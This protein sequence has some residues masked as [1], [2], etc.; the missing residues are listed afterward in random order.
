[1]NVP[2]RTAA[3]FCAALLLTACMP[4]KNLHPDVHGHRGCRG[5]LPEN[6][7]PGF[8]KAVE[9]GC[10][11]LEL[12]VVMSG[13]GQVIVSHEPWM[14]HVICRTAAGDSILPEQEQAFNIYHMTVAELQAFDCGGRPH[15]DFPEQ[16]DRRTSKPT[17]REVVE[18]VD[19][20]AVMNG[21]PIPSYNVEIKSDP[22]WY[23]TF[24]PEP[25]A[26]AEAVIATIDSLG[27]TDRCI[28][29][30]FDPAILE[31]VNA[32]RPDLQ[33]AF[34][35]ENSDGLEQDL[36]RLSFAPAIY[37]PQYTAAD[38]RLLKEL[39]ERGI[40]LVVWTVN[41]PKDIQRMLDLGVDGIISDYPD[42]VIKQME[43]Q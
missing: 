27:I 5:L 12:D 32:D 38:E 28:V 26:F 22:D 18:L 19:E 1:M 25:R 10:D 33:L 37:S 4:Q 7:I 41:E 9:L 3:A 40:D 31:A 42:R 24:Q 11:V 13:D 2:D 16:D 35:V 8:L 21:M 34:L 43:G 36:G 29:Q 39:R 14:S 30:S 20:H 23:G 6:S 15:P 17:L